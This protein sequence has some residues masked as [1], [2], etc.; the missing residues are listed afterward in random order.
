VLN[1]LGTLHRHRGDV[2]EAAR[3]HHAALSVAQEIDSAWDEAHA[4]AGLARCDLAT[5]QSADGESKLRQAHEIFQRMG[6]AET[7][8][9]AAELAAV[10]GGGAV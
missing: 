3:C 1:E 8:G 4:V 5:G 6:A 2:A 9:V 7:P 10:A